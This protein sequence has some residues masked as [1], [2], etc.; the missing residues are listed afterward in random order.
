MFRRLLQGI[1]FT[2]S[3]LLAGPSFAADEFPL[4][5]GFTSG[6][7]TIDGV[8]LH[9]VKG[10]SGPLVYLVHGFGQTCTNGTS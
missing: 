1:G 5:P 7:E 4:P 6:Y 10:G 3:L 2:L 8:R 9:Y